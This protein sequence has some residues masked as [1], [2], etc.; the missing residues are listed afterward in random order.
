MLKA[1]Y[2][3]GLRHDLALPPGFVGKTIKAYISLS[4]NNDRVSIYM[5]EQR[6]CG[7]TV[8][9]HSRRTRD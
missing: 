9:C 2:D 7:K 6:S 1:L 3:Y 8:C 5:G 4:E